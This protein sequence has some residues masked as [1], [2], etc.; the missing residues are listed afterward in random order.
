MGV[1][2]AVAAVASVAVAAGSTAIA[3]NKS[4]IAAKRQKAA[5]A[6]AKRSADEQTAALEALEAENAIADEKGV[7]RQRKRSIA[8][9]LGRGGRQSTI[10]TD[11]GS[12]GGTLGAS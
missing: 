6:A 10:L 2:A 12:G 9:Q 11:S 5:N 4:S 7:R 3:A 8:R 1:V